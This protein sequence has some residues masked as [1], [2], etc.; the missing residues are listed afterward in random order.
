MLK[1]G[2]QLMTDEINAI[3]TA[4]QNGETS[5]AR[6]MVKA[7]LKDR[8]TAEGWYLAAQLAD[9]EE[10]AMLMLR[11]ALELDALHDGANRMLYQLQKGRPIIPEEIQREW[12]RRIGE[13][14]LTAIARRPK[15]DRFQ[16][17]AER[18][19]SL[20]RIGCGFG[21]LLML[22]TTIFAFRAVGMLSEA[23]G[24]INSL[25]GHP[26]V[27]QLD[28]MPLANVPDAP[29]RI[30]P[31]MSAQA[32]GQAMEIVDAGYLHEHIFN[33]IGGRE[34][35]IYV[36]FV[37]L[38]ASQVSRNVVITRPDGTDFTRNCQQQRIIQGDNNVAYTCLITQS[39]RYAVRILGRAGE[40]V[41]AYFVGVTTLGS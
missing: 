5:R 9:D 19:R 40:S 23:A 28:G 25:F 37:S 12:N 41:G 18:Q 30:A 1:R 17:H 2:L 13:R 36:Q 8:P 39:G 4:I 31:S 33:A 6:Q 11:R 32:S 21:V 15:A 27:T 35:A 7:H 14:D 34:Y 24:F 20:T 29:L 16:R 3:R 38:N 22:S 26:P 10:R